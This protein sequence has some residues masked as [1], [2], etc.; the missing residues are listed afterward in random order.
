MGPNP[1]TA[2]RVGERPDTFAIGS[3]LSTDD[4]AATRDTCNLREAY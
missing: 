2:T 1:T 4:A 3:L